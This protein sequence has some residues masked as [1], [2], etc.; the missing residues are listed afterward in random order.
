MK[1]IPQLALII[2][3]ALSPWGCAV[4]PVTG[5]SELSLISE[6]Q[7]LAIG[8]E[9]YVPTQQIQGGQYSVDPELT[10]YVNTVGQRLAA[11]S[12]RALPYEF[13]VLNNSIPNAWALPGGKIAINRGLLLELNN[14]AELAAV[15]AHEIVHAAARHGAQTIN[16]NILMQGVLL[17]ATLSTSDSEYSN[18]IMGAATL[19]TRLVTQK[20]GRS[21]ELEADYYGMQYMARA[22]YNPRAAVALQKTFVRLSEDRK[23]NWLEGLFASHP[24][25]EERVNRNL[26]T[27]AELTIDGEYAE[28]RFQRNLAYLRSKQPAYKSFE[29]ARK[30]IANNEYQLAHASLDQAIKLEPKEAQ[31]YA[32]N[33]DLYRAQK[34]YLEAQQQYNKAMQRDA[35][36]YQIYLGRGL[37]YVRQNRYNLAKADLEKSNSLVPTAIAMNE[38]GKIA[39]DSGRRS[40]AKEYFQA[41][42]TAKG[43]VGQEATLA[44][45]KLDIAENPGR[46]VASQLFLNEDNGVQ[47][48]LTNRSPFN[49]GEVTIVLVRDRGGSSIQIIRSLAPSRRILLNTGVKVSAAQELSEYSVFIKSVA[50]L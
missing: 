36:W 11:V 40:Q 2:V 42:S 15:V 30:N 6:N 24:P 25:S 28:D 27:V 33:G 47:I 5:K 43:E 17:A 41:A 39:L 48:Q 37:N 14:E 20:Y 35:G 19:G 44:F 10:R 16:R 50:V 29:D 8:R 34:K 18:Y 21:A 32:L 31:F 9:Q 7:E 45:M 46:Y 22:G 49:L 12:D 4:N 3:L 1:L 23:T 26:R 13:V 38:L